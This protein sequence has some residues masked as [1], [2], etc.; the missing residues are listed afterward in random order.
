MTNNNLGQEN[1]G[2][3]DSSGS[4]FA[5]WSRFFVGIG[6]IVLFVTVIGPWITELP[7]F[8]PV[9]DVIKERGIDA[10]TYFYTETEQFDVAE[11]YMSEALKDNPTSMTTIIIGWVLFGAVLY[12]GFRYIKID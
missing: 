7:V 2:E 11:D 6:I 12:I 5:R 8:K 3:R 4:R 1:G 9:N 10:N